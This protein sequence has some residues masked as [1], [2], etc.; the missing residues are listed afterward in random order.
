MARPRKLSTEQEAEIVQICVSIMQSGE[1]IN[2][3]IVADKFGVCTTT[4]YNTLR[5]AGIKIPHVRTTKELSEEQ[6][7]LK[8]DARPCI[9]FE[10]CGNQELITWNSQKRYWHRSKRC[11]PC[12]HLWGAHGITP[13][14]KAKLFEDGCSINSCSREPSVIDHDHFICPQGYHSCEKCRRGALCH[15]HNS[16]VIALIDALRDGKLSAELNYLGIKAV[17]FKDSDNI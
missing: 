7:E 17:I 10:W 12:A 2:K 9:N 14:E 3:E 11:N 16:Q 8:P 4:I 13:E 1:I 6:L 15:Y 5:R